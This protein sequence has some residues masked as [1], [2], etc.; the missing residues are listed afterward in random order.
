[1]APRLSPDSKL[2]LPKVLGHSVPLTVQV[3][4]GIEIPFDVIQD[5]RYFPVHIKLHSFIL[6][7][8][9]EDM[10]LEG[11]LSSRVLAYRAYGSGF[12]SEHCLTL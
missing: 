1:M 9:E 6:E 5:S 7:E 4:S 3:V 10:G 11:Q 2:K 8:T 12:N